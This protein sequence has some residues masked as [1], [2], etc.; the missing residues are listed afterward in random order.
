MHHGFDDSSAVNLP[1]SEASVAEASLE[2]E[3]LPESEAS[4][5]HKRPE[6][7]AGHL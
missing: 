7:Q 4:I 5:A 2:R 6:E 1:S 3:S